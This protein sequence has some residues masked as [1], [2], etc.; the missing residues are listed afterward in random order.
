MGYTAVRAHSRRTNGRRASDFLPPLDPSLIRRPVD[1]DCTHPGW[2]P[3]RRCDPD[4]PYEDSPVLAYTCTDWAATR[5]AN[6][7][8]AARLLERRT[9]T[10]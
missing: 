5:P 7:P 8:E 10:L 2:Y 3:L 9:G 6:G 1:C 4:T